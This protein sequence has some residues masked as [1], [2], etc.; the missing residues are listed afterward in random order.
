MKDSEL[1]RY[2]RH[3]LLP[4][5]DIVGQE[6][7]CKSKVLVLGVG[8]LGSPV[9]MYLAAAGVR[10]LVLV[11]DDT[12]ALSNLQR[13]IAYS[14]DQIGEQKAIAAKE[15]ISD[16]NSSIKVSAVTDR[17]DFSELEKLLDGCDVAVDCTDN[18]AARQLINA[19]CF[20]KKLPLVYASAIRFEGQLS[21]FDFRQEDSPC[22]ECLYHS[23]GDIN[24]SCSESGVVS[25]LVGVMGSM[26]AI[27]VI[28]LLAGIES[29][30][31]SKIALFDALKSEWRYFKFLKN[32]SCD[33]CSH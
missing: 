9:A 8:G 31:V 28:K 3:I 12:V 30:L 14:Q 4:Q 17:P 19:S 11:D 33:V 29:S 2:S 18:L 32:A 6:A 7:L 22:Y 21:I 15:K 10:E 1:E 25:P 23:M 24:E 26:Q 13:Q 16:L 27:E 20:S 5:I